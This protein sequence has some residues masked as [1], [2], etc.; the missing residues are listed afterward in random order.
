MS[1]GYVKGGGLAEALLLYRNNFGDMSRKVA[2][3]I[4]EAANIEKMLQ[5]SLG[6]PVADKQLLEIG[7]GPHGAMTNFFAVRNKCIGIDI[8]VAHQGGLI[9]SFFADRRASGTSRAIRNL[10]KSALGLNKRYARE[11]ARQLGVEHLT[12]EIRRMD[13]TQLEFEADTFDGVYSLSAFEHIPNP[14]A[15]IKEVGRVLQP[16]GTA[17][18]ITHFITSDSGIHDPRLFDPRQELPWWPH[19]RSETKHLVAP[20]C[21]VNWIRLEDYRKMFDRE[22]PGAEH[23]LLGATDERR[24]EL[25]Q[26]RNEGLLQEYS[27]EELINDVLVTI[28]K[29]PQTS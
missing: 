7:P 13:A 17:V 18:I 2:E 24:K 1:V 29:R 22:W 21:Y 10:V 16:G 6:E 11:L 4:E 14:H 19:L 28:W 12:G 25:A 5:E 27:D 26:L 3:Q 23:R 20:N 15:V 9:T 8:E